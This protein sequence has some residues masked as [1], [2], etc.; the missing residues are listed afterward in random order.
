MTNKLFE[1]AVN[2][3]DQ[4]TPPIWFMRQA[5]RYHQHY[6]KLKEKYTFEELCKNPDLASE[7][8]CGPIKEFD[9]DL[10]ILFSDILFILEGLGLKLAFNPGPV[11]ENHINSKNFHL[12]NDLEKAI[13]HMKFQ[14]KALKLTREKLPNSKSLIGFVGGIWTLLKFA[15]NYKKDNFE[16]ED[17]HINFMSKTLLPLIKQ[18]IQLQLNAGAEVVMI[19]DSS[20]GSL[21]NDIFINN[22]FNLIL[23][24]SNSFP[25]KIGYYIKGKTYSDIKFLFTL[26]LAGIGIDKDVNIL[27]VIKNYKQGFVQ[28][29][30]DEKKM[31]LEENELKKELELY[32]NKM[33]SIDNKTGW[34]CSLGHGIDRMTP[35]KNVHLFIESIRKKF[36]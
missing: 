5:G 3:V 1:N 35:E 33:E 27:D 26:P 23:N 14:E 2:R 31:L 19:F 18:N 13:H 22:Y 16:I 32:C 4:R 30:F 34:I 24:L 8:A 6:R 15:I 10:A 7:V 11:F 17:F 29:N 20:L 25:G 28:G 12:Y 36:S 21:K 9:Y